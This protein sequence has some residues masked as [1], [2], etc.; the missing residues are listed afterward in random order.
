MSVAAPQLGEMRR[1]ETKII[2]VDWGKKTDGLETGPLTNG[3]TV[4][5]CTVAVTS[6]PTSADDP[7]LGSVTVNTTTFTLYGRVVA[8][9]EATSCSIV[10]SSTQ[11]YGTYLL[12]FTATTT[13]SQIYK[14][15]T[16]INVTP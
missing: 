13:N 10:A 16:Q 14:A 1:G 6:K 9:G 15:D 4:A 12:R 11:T 3:D 7:T 5:S 2:R 8:A